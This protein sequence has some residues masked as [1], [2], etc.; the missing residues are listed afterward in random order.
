MSQSIDQD[1]GSASR[2]VLLATDRSQSILGEIVDGQTNTLSYSAYGE[3]SAQQKVETRLGFNGQLR[4]ASIG[5]YLLGNGYR[6]YNPRLMRF[7]CPD[8]WSPFGGGGLNAYMYCVGDPVNRVDPTGHLGVLTLLSSFRDLGTIGY[9]TSVL[10]TSLNIG[11]LVGRGQTTLANGLGIISG[12]TG[13]AAGASVLMDV[14]PVATQ[15]LSAT[16]LTSGAASSYLG[17]RSLRT[18]LQP[19]AEVRFGSV[20]PYKRPY[21]SPPSYFSHD[22]ASFT[23]KLIPNT[24]REFDAPPPRYT[25]SAP[26]SSVQPRP[27]LPPYSEQD[28]SPLIQ[29]IHENNR[30]VLVSAAIIRQ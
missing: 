11:V 8:S 30:S 27:P 29:P 26:E 21:E 22:P 19:T 18:L 15:L 17:V 6:A 12:L 24:V 5:W 7:H 13:M 2:V 25:H 23:G 20:A 14:A 1:N 16:S 4:E 10:G 28:M 3:Q 9:V